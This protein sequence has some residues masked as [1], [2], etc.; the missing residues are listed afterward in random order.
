MVFIPGG[1]FEF[2]GPVAGDKDQ[3]PKKQSF[4][5]KPFCID[6]SEAPDAYELRGLVLSYEPV[7]AT[8]GARE[9]EC[10]YDAHSG[11]PLTCVTPAQ[12]ECYCKNIIP[13]VPKR[14]PTDAE[15]LYA[16]LGTDGRLFPWGNEL[17]PQGL[18]GPAKDFCAYE[19]NV[20]PKTSLCMPW[21]NTRDKSPFGV[22]GMATNGG[23]MT[24][25]EPSGIARYVIRGV[26]HVSQ[27]TPADLSLVRDVRLLNP[28]SQSSPY[29]SFRCVVTRRR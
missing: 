28:P 19:V 10:L 22:I 25:R 4:D 5:I 26:N 3:T 6:S 16:A 15:F 20:D 12:A 7:E 27:G 13:G 8:C 21:R 18:T 1:K 2:T 11:G 17:Y 23:E 14:L 24:V 29:L 9:R